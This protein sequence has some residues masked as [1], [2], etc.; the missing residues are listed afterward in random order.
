M[1][2]RSRAAIIVV[3]A[4]FVFARRE[5]ADAPPPWSRTSSKLETLAERVSPPPGGRRTTVPPGSFAAWL[6]RLPLRPLGTT[7][8]LFDGREKSAQGV[9]YAVVDLDIGTRDLQQCADAV[10]RLR[11][12]Y[13]WAR[14]CA[15]RVSFD[16]TDGSPARWIEWR[17]GRRPVVAGG[18]VSWRQRAPMDSSYAAFRDY[19]NSVFTF[20]GSR[21][22]ARQL[23]LVRDPAQVEPGDVFIHGGSPGHAVLVVDVATDAQ[24]GRMFMLAQSYMPA[25][26]I[27][28][29]LNPEL[30]NTPWYP[31]LAAGLL[32][33]PEW[34]FDYREL[35]RF[36]GG[37]CSG[38]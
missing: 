19:L 20:A 1:D 9:V 38:P 8:R 6:R 16:F 27:H 15:G 11:A 12:E 28:V 2:L 37:D 3:A 18:R 31:A 33:T 4:L 26:D 32:R 36:P 34:D 7:V 13:L 5:T 30:G 21:S 17:S 23:V 29:L 35:R 25:Q 10:M 24:G 14:G 22:L